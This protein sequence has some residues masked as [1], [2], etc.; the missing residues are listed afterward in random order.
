MEE[1]YDHEDDARFEQ[2]V[3]RLLDRRMERMMEELTE[4]ITQMM[5]QRGG[6][7][8]GGDNRHN[9]DE[10]RRWES[11]IR[12]DISEFHGGLQAEEFLDWLTTV[13]E[14]LEFK[15]VP[16][17]RRV[18]LVATRLRGRAT[19]W[20]Q[21]LKLNCSTLAKDK[22]N[23]WEKMKKHMHSN[24]L[25]H[26]Y[27]RVIFIQESTDQ[28]VARYISG[29]RTKIQETFNLFDPISILATHQQALIIERQ[30]RRSVLLSSGGTPGGDRPTPSPTSGPARGGITAE[31]AGKRVML[32]EEEEETGDI[33]PPVFDEDILDEEIV[34]GDI[35]S[36]ENIISDEAVQKLNIS[37]E[38]HPTPYK[39][40]WLKRGG[41]LMVSKRAFVTFS[42]GPKYRDEVCGVKIV[43]VPN[44]PVEAPNAT[45][46]NLL[47]YAPFGRELQ[48]SGTA[49][50][51]LGKTITEEVLPNDL[52]GGLPP[53]R[54][55]QHQIE[56]QLGSILPHRPHYRMSPR[57]HEELR[58]QVKELLAKGHVRESMSPCAFP[59]LLT[60]KKDGTWR[61][62]V[63][64]RAINKITI[65]YR[66]P[67]PRLDDLLDQISGA[68]VFTRLDL[69]SG[70]HQIRVR[71]VD[72]WKTAFKTREVLYE[73]M[74]MPFGLS[75][76]PSTFMRVMNQLLRPFIGKFV[77]VY[78]DDILIYSPDEK[79]H[80]VHVRDVLTTLQSQEFYAAKKKCVFFTPKVLFL[81]YVVSGEGIQVDE[82]KIK[83]IQDW[84]T[85]TTITEVR[86]FH[87]LASFY[88]RFI[89]H[90]SSIMTPLTECM[91]GSK[92]TWTAD[93]EVAF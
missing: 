29:L 9:C 23:S 61:M 70:Y 46:T 80:L 87:G 51:L 49:F 40:A 68:T 36:C 13:E 18:V 63:D 37:I 12:V 73:W 83:A 42:I 78:F 19:A 44:K 91:K 53:L 27:Q 54:D 77:V 59:A 92:F 41:E 67:I 2:R 55:M 34:E 20:W 74:V 21:Q 90:F 93:A 7:D 10:D 57:E 39:L 25:P 38:R 72:E 1:I 88:R 85:P 26:N 32:V 52:P 79:M 47:S 75:N 69:K 45:N 3:G 8:R 81:G 33:L 6:Q 30:Q 82:A 62:C 84:P 15:G 76:A 48:D 4:R 17:D 43:L 86:S 64:S 28:L 65:R 66:F 11:G 58:C 24:F 35:G 14:I 5:G 22:I 31:K 56:L 89:A 50:V 71:P 16:D 60:P